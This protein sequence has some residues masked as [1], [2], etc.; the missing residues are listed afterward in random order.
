MTTQGH[1]TQRASSLKSLCRTKSDNPPILSGQHDDV[2][3][4]DH[5]TDR[6]PVRGCKCCM[7]CS[8]R[9]N[10]KEIISASQPQRIHASPQDGLESSLPH[11]P[12]RGATVLGPR[13]LGKVG[14]SVMLNFSS[15][16]TCRMGLRRVCGEVSQLELQFWRG[17]L[18]F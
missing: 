16:L 14:Q 7:F 2:C 5:P 4:W 13:I 3:T 9:I 12:S 15:S 17:S 10:S 6:Q 1:C 8:Q 11:S 18:N